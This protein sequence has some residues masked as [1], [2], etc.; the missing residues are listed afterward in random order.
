MFLQLW[1]IAVVAVFVLI[2]IGSWNWWGWWNMP[3]ISISGRV[4]VLTVFSA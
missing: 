3:Y 1:D 4:V 2:T